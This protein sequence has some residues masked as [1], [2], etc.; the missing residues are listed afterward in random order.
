MINMTRYAF[1]V[2]RISDYLTLS[3]HQTGINL[4]RHA[5]VSKHTENVRLLAG[6]GGLRISA[7]N[8]SR[9]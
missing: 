3:V 2:Q 9:R 8:R 4:E 5:R 7:D 6:Y 1:L